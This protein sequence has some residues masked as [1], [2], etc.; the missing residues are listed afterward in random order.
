MPFKTYN[1]VCNTFAIFLNFNCHSKQD[2]SIVASVNFVFLC[3]SIQPTITAE[4]C[5]NCQTAKTKRY[6][7]ANKNQN[8]LKLQLQFRK[9][10][11][12][13]FKHVEKSKN[14]MIQPKARVIHSHNVRPMSLYKQN[15]NANHICKVTYKSTNQ[16]S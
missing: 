4:T 16:S 9:C 12:E 13:T 6:T 15:K 14:Q 11:K 10:R 3:H 1:I 2:N 5:L 8:Y 7:R